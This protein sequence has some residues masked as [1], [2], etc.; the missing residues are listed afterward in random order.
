LI[1]VLDGTMGGPMRCGSAGLP[2]GAMDGGKVKDP[3]A[4]AQ[5]LRQLL[6]RTEIT[7]T[8]ALVAANDA[9]ATFR[10]LDLPPASTEKDVGAAVA[11]DLPLDPERMATT[12]F[13]LGTTED[14]RTVYA[15]AWDR[16]LVKDVTD[17]VKLAGLEATVVDLKSACVARTVTY[18]SCVVV[19]LSADPV[20]IVLIDDHVPQLW[21]TFGLAVPLSE[22]IAPALA[23]PLRSVIRFYRRRAHSTFGPSSPILISAEQVLPVQ[24]I[25]R[26]ADLLEQP[27]MALPAPSRVAP[28]VRHATYLTCLGL[29]MRRA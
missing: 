26:L 19:D 23:P 29:I 11:K 28:H 16:S 2:P 12:W 3:N 27:V 1:R 25:N 4:V 13:D 22:D 6:A 20:E 21:H 15:A 17:S 18:P 5:V 9:M 8:R 10:I 14:R 24:V 7:E